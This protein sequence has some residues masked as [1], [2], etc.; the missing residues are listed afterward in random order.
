M[1]S[2]EAPCV[3]FVN[4]TQLV[5]PASRLL[6]LACGHGRHARFFAERG[7]CVTA[8]DR[9]AAALQSLA[10]TQNV[11]AECRDIEGDAWP[12]LQDSFDVIIVC[13]YLWR[14][15]FASVLAAIKPGGVLLYE[16]FMDGNERYGKPSRPD[17]LLRSNELLT[18]TRN[19]FRIV[20]YEEGD[21]LDAAGQPFAV[22]QKIAAIKR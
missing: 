11:I 14:P 21:A 19:T 10:T 1:H 4:H 5:L 7:A 8:V 17:F 12:Y 22:K 9:D 15:T 6:D 16:T 18:L 2:Q 13:N 3:W 20:A